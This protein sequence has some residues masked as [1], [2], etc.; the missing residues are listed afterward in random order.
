MK[1]YENPV[2]ASRPSKPCVHCDLWVLTL[3]PH[4]LPYETVQ[5]YRLVYVDLT[6]Y[7]AAVSSCHITS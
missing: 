3:V 5:V 2:A 4:A 1:R 6:I 7:P